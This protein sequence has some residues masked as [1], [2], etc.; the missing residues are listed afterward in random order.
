MAGRGPRLRG[1]ERVDVGD[2]DVRRHQDDEAAQHGFELADFGAEGAG[3]GAGELVAA[4]DQPRP[5][6][7]RLQ[8]IAQRGKPRVYESRS[9]H[10]RAV[11]DE[12]RREGKGWDVSGSSTQS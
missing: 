4:K 6:G 3:G 1:D 9:D 11:W 7:G 12:M 2:F 8:R 10:W 5:L